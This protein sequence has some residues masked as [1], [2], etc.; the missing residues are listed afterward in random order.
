MTFLHVNQWVDD[1]TWARLGRNKHGSGR[2]AKMK[3]EVR[4][5]MFNPRNHTR[6]WSPFILHLRT[7]WRFVFSFMPQP[8]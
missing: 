8:V 3:L 2:K 5:E 6:D 7:R 4:F 1:E